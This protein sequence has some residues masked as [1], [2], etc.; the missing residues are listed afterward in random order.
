M[1]SDP[2]AYLGEQ[3]D[4]WRKAGTYQSLRQLESACEPVAR[5]DGREHRAAI[6]FHEE[7]V[8]QVAAVIEQHRPRQ[9]IISLGLHIGQR[10]HRQSG[11]KCATHVR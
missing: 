5:F 2:L 4:T 9:R 8:A 1:S 7:V 3:I 11:P 6:D 10:P